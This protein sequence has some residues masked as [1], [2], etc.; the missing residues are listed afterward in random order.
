M[1]LIFCLFWSFLE[2]VPPER[3]TC[4]IEAVTSNKEKT[5]RQNDLKKS[6]FDYSN[7]N[8]DKLLNMTSRVVYQGALRT[9]CTHLQS[10]SAIETDAPVD[11][12]GK[13]ERFSPTDLLAT[14]L[15][16]CMLTVMGIKARDMEID[17]T[18]LSISVQKNMLSD[19][20]RVGSIELF[21]TI[22][23]SLQAL[24]EK[25]KQVLKR[26]GESCPVIKSIHPDIV[27]TID[28]AQWA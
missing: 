16:T 7:V 21:A 10:G 27:V 18:G 6:R 11:N 20:R 22:P 14:S 28:W 8:L 25:T 19:P 13:G 24:E 1:A 2:S 17:M 26:T 23:A 5:V 12:Q 9:T 3:V 4:A 15:A